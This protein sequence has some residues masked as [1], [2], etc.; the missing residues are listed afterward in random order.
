M[1]RVHHDELAIRARDLWPL[2]VQAFT[3][4]AISTLIAGGTSSGLVLVLA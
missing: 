3:L 2:P 4:A 1:V